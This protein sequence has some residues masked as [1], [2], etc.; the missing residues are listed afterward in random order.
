MIFYI[1]MEMTND[2]HY[3]H[4]ADSVDGDGGSTKTLEL[5]SCRREMIKR[6]H[7]CRQMKLQ[8]T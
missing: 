1:V 3:F 6:D 4:P 8:K 7:F 5:T 2:I